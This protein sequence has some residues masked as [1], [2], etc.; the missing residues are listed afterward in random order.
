MNLWSLL[1]HPDREEQASRSEVAEAANVLEIGEFQLL[2]LAYRW[3][4]GHELPDDRAGPLFQLA[5]VEGREPAW[6]LHYAQ[7]ILERAREGRL[8]VNDP[9]YHRY[10]RFHYGP[11][12][13]QGLAFWVM[14]V[15]CG[16]LLL[17]SVTLASLV[18]AEATS[19]L[20]PFFTVQEL[21][22]GN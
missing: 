17:G 8:N 16:A 7:L 19:V 11:D 12:A 13:P 6:A 22:Q 14:A 2:Q 21:P 9:T 1:I 10:D 20:P 18:S 5:M 15:G 3:R 4:F